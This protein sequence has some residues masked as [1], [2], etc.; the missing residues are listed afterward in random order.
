MKNKTELQQCKCLS[1]TEPTKTGG[2]SPFGVALVAQHTEKHITAILS[3][4][5]VNV[6]Y[7]LVGRTEQEDRCRFRDGI[8]LDDT[9]ST[10]LS[11][12][13]PSRIA[14]FVRPLAGKSSVK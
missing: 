7:L 5:E 4:L 14:S 1:S 13:F 3:L 12:V 6:Q 11:Y 10:L 9:C 8:W 2:N